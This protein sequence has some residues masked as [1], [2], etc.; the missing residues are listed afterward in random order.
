MSRLNFLISN[1]C[2]N[3]QTGSAKQKLQKKCNST[4]F[5]NHPIQ[6]NGCYFWSNV[7][8]WF[9]VRCWISFNLLV[10][11]ILWLEAPSTTN[12]VCRH[13]LIFSRGIVPHLQD[14]NPESLD[15]SLNIMSPILMS[16]DT[17]LDI[18][19][20]ILKV[21]IPVSISRLGFQKTWSWSS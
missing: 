19:T 9:P 18:K 11:S 12:W 7:V 2:P 20:T 16:L 13:N 4:Y 6:Q 10:I 15:T 5:K 17:S 8:I 1:L 14:C 3:L 21:L